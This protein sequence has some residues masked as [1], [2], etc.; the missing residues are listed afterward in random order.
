MSGATERAYGATAARPC[1]CGSS[2]VV[3]LVVGTPERKRLL[4][5]VC[6]SCEL[7]RKLRDVTE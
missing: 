6:A 5:L 7:P 3:A 1:V 4:S 2:R